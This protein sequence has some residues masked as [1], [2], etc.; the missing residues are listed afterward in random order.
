MSDRLNLDL[1]FPFRN[2]VA[3]SAEAKSVQRKQAV[4]VE[5][6][7]KASTTMYILFLYA[8]E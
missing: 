5:R 6:I 7:D 1:T 2:V 3:A 8:F 4:G